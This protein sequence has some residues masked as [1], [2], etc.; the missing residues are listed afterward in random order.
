MFQFY[1]YFEKN[2]HKGG[3]FKLHTFPYAQHRR[4]NQQ[5]QKAKFISDL[6][7]TL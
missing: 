5:L 6:A 7:K 4:F 1:I 3:I 2:S